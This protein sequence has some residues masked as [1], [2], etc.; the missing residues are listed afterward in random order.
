MSEINLEIQHSVKK[1]IERMV[2]PVHGEHPKVSFSSSGFSVSCCCQEFRSKA[3]SESEKAIA[4]AVRQY[5]ENTL[6]GS[7]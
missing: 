3:I 6:N 5:I 4:T 2:C 7:F 1:Q